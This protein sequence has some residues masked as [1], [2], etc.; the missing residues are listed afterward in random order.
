MISKNKLSDNDDPDKKS[1]L[2]K[3]IYKR[4][5]KLYDYT[6][7]GV[8]KRKRVG[9]EEVDKFTERWAA[10]CFFLSVLLFLLSFEDRVTWWE[11]I[12]LFVGTVRVVEMLIVVARILLFHGFKLEESDEIGPFSGPRRLI[13]LLLIN[14]VELTFWFSLINRNLICLSKSC[15][16]EP[17]QALAFS[18]VNMSGVGSSP[19]APSHPA[20]QLLALLQ[21]G[22][23]VFMALT[24]L[25]KFI[26]YLPG[27]EGK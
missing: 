5:T 1:P 18:F 19:Y 12:F 8:V 6:P 7:Y 15:L 21:S 27:P 24:V 23:G 9:A 3:F 11:G 17:I 25:A 26:S 2:V 20:G 13:L 16:N 14:Y 4:L 22:I 10:G